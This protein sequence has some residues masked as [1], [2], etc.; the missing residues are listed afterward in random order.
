MFSSVGETPSDVLARIAGQ[1]YKRHFNGMFRFRGVKEANFRVL[2]STRC[3]AI[4]VENLFFDNYFE[5][6]YLLSDEGQEAIANCLLDIVRSIH[7]YY[8]AN[9]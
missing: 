3:P 5:A 8:E 1:E 9:S 6:K 7:F 4:L 2:K